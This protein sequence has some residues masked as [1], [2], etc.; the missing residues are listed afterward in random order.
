MRELKLPMESG[1]KLNAGSEP[2]TKARTRELTYQ[3]LIH[4][5]GSPQSGVTAI[6]QSALAGRVYTAVAMS[7]IISS[8]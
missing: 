7:A 4:E 8:R 2:T 6:I 5:H 1:W 3:A